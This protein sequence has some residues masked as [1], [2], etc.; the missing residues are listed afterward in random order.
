VVRTPNNIE[1]GRPQHEGRRDQLADIVFDFSNNL[2]SAG[3]R[4]F[5]GDWK[6]QQRHRVLNTE[7]C[8][9]STE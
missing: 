5:Q 1:E 2:D 9:N 7:D 3:A 6:W 8:T 4:R